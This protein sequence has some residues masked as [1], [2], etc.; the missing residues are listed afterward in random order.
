MI[1]MEL[2][3]LKVAC[4][5]GSSNMAVNSYSKCTMQSSI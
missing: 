1:K 5:S 2:F 3:I 4:K